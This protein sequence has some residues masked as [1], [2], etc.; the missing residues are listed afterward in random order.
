[1]ADDAQGAR[2]AERQLTFIASAAAESPT[3]HAMFL[4]ALMDRETPP[5]RVTVVLAKEADAD[6]LPLSLPPDASVTL[7]RQ[8]TAEYPL[9]DGQT[10][11]YICRDHSCLPA[12]NDPGDA[13]RSTMPEKLQAR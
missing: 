8:P 4:L 1:M 13:Y 2:A 9:K 10:T 7:L 12:T 3:D 11:F 5:S 6:G